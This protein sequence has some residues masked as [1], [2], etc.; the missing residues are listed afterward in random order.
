L[1][2]EAGGSGRRTAAV[3]LPTKT[4][5]HTQQLAASAGLVD[6][7]AGQRRLGLLMP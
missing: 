6:P 1:G 3:S 7:Q 4:K 5:P 2:L